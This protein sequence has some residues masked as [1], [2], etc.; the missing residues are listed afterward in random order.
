MIFGS[1]F[2]SEMND[3]NKNLAPIFFYVFMIIFYF[4]VMKFFQ[5]WLKP[6]LTTIVKA[7]IMRTYDDLRQRK[8]LVTEAM[9]M[10]LAKE[11]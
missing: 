4:I 2:Y 11:T 1:I 8:Q 10:I 5:V 3:S 6:L 9:A 7:I